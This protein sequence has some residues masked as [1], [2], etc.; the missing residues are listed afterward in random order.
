MRV[1]SH[2]TLAELAPDRRGRVREAGVVFPDYLIHEESI[3]EP[4]R[5]YWLRTVSSLK[6][7]VTELYIHPAKASDALKQMTSYWHVRADEYKLFTNDP[8][9]LAVLKKH[10]VK[11]IGWRALRDL[12]RGER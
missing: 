6:P 2:E 9:M 4:K 10:D 8:K 1:A 3:E 11:L 12:Q 5:E 7:G